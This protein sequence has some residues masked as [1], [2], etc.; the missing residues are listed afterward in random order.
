[1]TSRDAWTVRRSPAALLGRACPVQAFALQVF[2]TH[3]TVVRVQNDS[4]SQRIHC[5]LE[6]FGI[7]AYHVR[8]AFAGADAPVPPCR[9]REI[10]DTNRVL[11]YQPPVIRVKPAFQCPPYAL[12][13]AAILQ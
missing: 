11:F 9:Q 5:D 13:L 3:C 7:A 8:Y 6:A 10:T 2:H 12:L 1:M 4:G